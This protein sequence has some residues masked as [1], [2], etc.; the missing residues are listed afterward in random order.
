MTISGQSMFVTVVAWLAI[1]GA[2]ASASM[3]LMQTALLMFAMPDLPI[4]ANTDAGLDP[5]SRFVFGNFRA[6]AFGQTVVWC[7]AL[8]CAVGLLRRRE[9][10][11]KGIVLLLLLGLAMV[12]G[13]A[14][15]QQS[16]MTEMLAHPDVGVE[17][18]KMAVGMRIASGVMAGVLVALMAWLAAR[19][20]SHAI[21]TE[22]S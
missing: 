17:A 11:R 19:L 2:G 7:V 13:M 22:F 14:V 4:G 1:I 15:W 3:G 8:A 5:V 6:V 9:W 12:A 18:G 16:V 20:N 21:K 10:G